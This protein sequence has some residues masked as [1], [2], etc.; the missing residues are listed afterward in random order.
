ML[1]LALWGYGVLQSRLTVGLFAIATALSAKIFNL[2]SLV[3][4]RREDFRLKSVF[5][6]VLLFALLTLPA[7]A[8]Y[9]WNPFEMIRAYI[10]TANSQAEKL[11]GGQYGLPSLFGSLVVGV[12]VA[13]LVALGFYLFARRRLRD[14]LS[15]FA[16]ALACALLHEP[17]VLL[18]DEPTNGVDPVSRRE[19]WAL[20]H[21][22]VHGGMTV[23]VSTP[24]MDEAE[25]C[26]RVGLVHG[27]RL[28]LDGRPRELLAASGRPSFEELFISAVE[29]APAP[30]AAGAAT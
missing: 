3:G 2:F 1:A 12:T 23:L 22:F 10:G 28:L 18:L 11:V 25:R 19:L 8:G 26:S 21:E 7:L 14:D 16:L 15:R 20:L 30:P 9:G 29:H 13:V 17:E 24:Y 6:C 27:G 5:V 4:L